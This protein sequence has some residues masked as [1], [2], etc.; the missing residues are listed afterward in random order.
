MNTFA[1][2]ELCLNSLSAVS[3]VAMFK[4][5]LRDI[6]GEYSWSNSRA[7][8]EMMDLGQS[9]EGKEQVIKWAEQA[10][11]RMM[12]ATLRRARVG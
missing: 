2:V 5:D 1:V 4:D 12:T 8:D 3:E 6:L 11:V 10:K 9:F 7:R